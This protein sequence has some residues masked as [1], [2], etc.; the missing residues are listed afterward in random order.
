MRLG[1]I[2]LVTGCGGTEPAPET[3]A[4]EPPA[5]P[6]EAK[7]AYMEAHFTGLIEARDALIRG[8]V[9]GAQAKLRAMTEAPPPDGL[10]SEWAPFIELQKAA[11]RRAEYTTDPQAVGRGIAAAAHVCGECHTTLA[12][13]VELVVVAAPPEKSGLIAHMHRHVWAADRM[14]QGLVGPS[15]GAWADAA[16]VLAESPLYEA[17]EGKLMNDAARAFAVQVV[18]AGVATLTA[19]SST[20]RIDL[21]GD[22][23]G[24]CGSCHVVTS[25]GPAPSPE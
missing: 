10:P 7:A 25:G 19:A 2:A 3:L 14:W 17:P 4:P 1:W 13:P 8:D 22:F 12:V 23:L 21:Y 20:E 18:D 11:M 5:A 15:S 6:V 9:L 16:A 24:A